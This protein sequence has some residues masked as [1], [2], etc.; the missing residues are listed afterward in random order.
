MLFMYIAIFLVSHVNNQNL[1][2]AFTNYKQTFTGLTLNSLSSL[3]KLLCL[4]ISSDMTK[5]NTYFI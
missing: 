2:Y 4:E 1:F 5:L 3:I